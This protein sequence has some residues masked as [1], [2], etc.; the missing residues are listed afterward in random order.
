[1]F[2][3]CRLT[4]L[5]EELP[6]DRFHALVTQY[7]ADKHCKGFRSYHQLVALLYG[8]FSGAS[9]LRELEVGFN[10]HAVHH[11][12]L[13]ARAVSRSTLA[14]A[15]SKRPCAMFAELAQALMGQVSRRT[16]KEAGCVQLLDSTTIT[17]KGPGYDAWT[18]HTRTRCGQGLKLH[19][20]WDMASATPQREVIGPTN[21][22]D[23]DEAVDMP[24]E[25]GVTYVFDR[26]YCDYAWWGRIGEAG[27]HFVTRF[28]SNAALVVKE[29]RKIPADTAHAH[30]L[31]DEEV[32]F[33]YDQPRGGRP[34]S[35]KLRLRRITVARPDHD[36]PLVFATNDLSRSAAQIAQCYRA[37][38]Q[39]ELF[40]KWIKQ[41]LKVKRFLG[42]S[43]NAVR[44]QLYCALIAYL[45]LALY[46]AKHA[47]T[48][49]RWTQ[50]YELRVSLFQRPELDAELY[51]R[52]CERMAE[53]Q[54][55]Q[56][57]L[58]G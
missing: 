28:K 32:E 18:A 37:R 44:I 42:R 57:Q 35:P 12:H 56:G 38:W 24:L 39:V 51:R 27:A 4:Q 53:M 6:R 15:N 36:E 13:G 29:T 43:Q 49:D 19:V 48:Q 21:V 7:E 54:A 8:Q 20:L 11:Y 22:N 34:A 5:L 46:C 2:R 52:R 3:V 14:D 26:A 47:L 45:L 9:S 41:H 23:R 31:R 10:R 50:M 40:F 33:E 25:K 55:R 16:R 1:M 58:W 30:V 17:L